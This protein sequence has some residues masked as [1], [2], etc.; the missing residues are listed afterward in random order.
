MT[1]QEEV[2]PNIGGTNAVEPL[3]DSTPPDVESFPGPSSVADW[4]LHQS[5]LPPHSEA[6]MMP[7]SPPESV[8]SSISDFTHSILTSSQTRMGEF[9]P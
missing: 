5:R 2:T 6:V 1:T 4:R 3:P 7:Q 9:S 8:L